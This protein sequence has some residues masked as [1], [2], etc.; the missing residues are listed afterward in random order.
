M[1]DRLH[2]YSVAFASR[3]ASPRPLQEMRAPPSPEQVALGGD[4]PLLIRHDQ[5]P[6]KGAANLIRWRD[7]AI[8]KAARLTVLI[9]T[10]KSPLEGET[11]LDRLV[12]I[13]QCAKWQEKLDRYIRRAVVLTRGIGGTTGDVQQ[14]VLKA[15]RRKMSELSVAEEFQKLDVERRKSNPAR[16]MPVV[17]SKASAE[18]VPAPEGIA[19]SEI[20]EKVPDPAIAEN[21][22]EPEDFDP[23]VAFLDTTAPGPET[24]A[25]IDKLVAAGSRPGPEFAQLLI[26]HERHDVIQLL[27]QRDLMD[28]ST[29]VQCHESKSTLLCYG[30]SR[31]L[32]DDYLIT[33]VEKDADLRTEDAP[34][35]I[36]VGGAAP[37][38]TEYRHVL[39]DI[40][41][42]AIR[43]GWSEPRLLMLLE[44]KV[45]K[46]DV[47]YNRIIDGK[48][49][50]EILYSRK[51][52]TA[53]TD[54]IA[55]G[56]PTNCII[57]GRTFLGKVLFDGGPLARQFVLCRLESGPHVLPFDFHTK[58]DLH[59]KGANGQ[60]ALHDLCEGKFD[61]PIFWR[62][63][64]LGVDPY[65]KNAN[66]KSAI[67]IMLEQ[68][69]KKT[70]H[71]ATRNERRDLLRRVKKEYRPQAKT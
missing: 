31:E 26:D 45:R 30:L 16:S 2:T 14:S 58:F 68:V 52:H 57:D 4:A 29:R 62:M 12:R 64:N 37:E 24:D 28:P 65:A 18:D 1:S 21:D 44:W 51:Y 5:V 34:V 71:Q 27:V 55:Y 70:G 53:L 23:W 63:L 39:T 50:L 54:L 59:A 20:V 22:L 43:R 3:S 41:T 46:R 9:K 56:A 6:A 40:F 61:E 36:H 69:E 11:C 10:L 7:R 48:N 8:S 67:D 33:L 49:L 15:V 38:P 17:P 66:G 32:D 13:E 25:R 19:I 35:R 42:L 47:N 60:T